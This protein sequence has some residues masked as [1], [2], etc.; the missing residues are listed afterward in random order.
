MLEMYIHRTV[1]GNVRLEEITAIETGCWINLV[2]P[3]EDELRKVAREANVPLDFLR[4]PLDEEERPRIDYEDDVNTVLV[5]ADFPYF[6]Q[7]DA[8][9]KY[10]TLPFGILMNDLCIITVS[11]RKASSLELL[12]SGHLRDFRTQYHTRFCL[13]ILLYGAQEYLKMLRYIDKLIDEAEQ[14]LARS[15][16]NKDCLP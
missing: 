10:V 9:M 7:I 2:S 16:S 8:E 1:E 5:I 3:T 13:Q 15:V 4:Y 11:L 14:Q 6:D 12:K